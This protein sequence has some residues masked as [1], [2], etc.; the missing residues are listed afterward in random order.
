[1]GCQWIANV[2]RA[3]QNLKA[4]Q[5]LHI[6]SWV[7]QECLTDRNGIKLRSKVNNRVYH[8]II[9]NP[10]RGEFERYIMGIGWCDFLNDHK[11]KVGERLQ[12]AV[13]TSRL[14]VVDIIRRKRRSD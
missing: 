7:V 4:K 12:F 14:M 2:T 10:G 13:R 5:T 11:P 8:C 1:G 3:V 9:T 6:P